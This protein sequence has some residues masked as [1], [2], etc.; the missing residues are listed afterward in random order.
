MAVG[1]E[2]AYAEFLGQGEGL[3]VVGFS[4]FGVWRL[5]MLMFHSPRM[6]RPKT[7]APPG[8]ARPALACREQSLAST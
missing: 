7:T 3:A 6:L 2:R 5:K 4:L 8:K 1:L